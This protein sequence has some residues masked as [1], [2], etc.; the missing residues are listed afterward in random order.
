M[1]LAP[2]SGVHQ[3]GEGHR[4]AL[5]E[6]EVGEGGQGGVHLLG[7][8]LG[9][10][11]GGHPVEQPVSEPVHALAGPLGPHGLAQL[12]GLGRG[13]AGHVDGD[14]HQL[15][16]EEGDA[17][18]PLQRRLEQRMQVGDVLLAVAPPDVGMDGVALDGPGADEGHLDGQVVEAAGLHPGQGAHLG[19]GLHLE[20]PHGVGPAQQ[21]VD[22]GLLADAG[23][24]RSRRCGGRAT[25]STML[26]RAVSMPSPS[27]SNLTSPAAA[28]S[29][30]SHCS[31]LRPGIRAH[32]TGQTSTTGRSQMT[33]PPE[34]MP[35]CRG[36]SSTA[37]GQVAHHRGDGLVVVQR[38]APVDRPGPALHLG[39]RVPEGLA[40]V[41]EGRAGAVGDDV[42]H[43]GRVQA[44]VALVDVL[45]DFLPSA[46]LDVD[47]DVRGAVAGGG[48]EPL[49]Q[50]TQRHRVHVGDAQGVTDGRGG[51]RAPALAE[52]V[53]FSAE[54]HDVPDGEEVAGEPEGADDGRARGRGAPRRPDTRSSSRGP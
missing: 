13:E 24:G 8:L 38:L 12:V 5:G 41:A 31:T 10:I 32:S 36:K 48:E 28:Q 54:P 50:Q 1:Q 7:H 4:V 51:G 22:L 11:P 34:W 3:V 30:L 33:M 45:D 18:R 27:R 9:H 15:L 42:G 35:R 23:P 43:L 40:D 2:G 17:E 47:V 52:D 16:L 44:A 6:P 25:R 46:R 39:Q 29:S 37:P 53:L 26:W 49:E 19:P 21:V 14:L 20:H